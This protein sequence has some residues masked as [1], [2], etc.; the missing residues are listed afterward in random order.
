[1]SSLCAYNCA[2]LCVLHVCVCAW[3]CLAA[4]VC[5]V[6]TQVYLDGNVYLAVHGFVCGACRKLGGVVSVSGLD[7]ALSCT[8]LW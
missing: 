2:Y 7:P 3:V 4:T 1:M 6:C 8:D 5:S